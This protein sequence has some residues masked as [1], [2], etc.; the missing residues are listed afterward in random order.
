MLIAMVGLAV[1]L[2]AGRPA[3][4][5]V[6]QVWDEAHFLK[7][8]TIDPVDQVLNDIQSRFG[9]DLMIE[10]FASIPDDLKPNLQKD[11]KDKFYEGWSVSEGQEL[12]INGLLIL[13]TGDP[14]HIQV[15]VG[16]DT[17]KKAFTLADRDELL[18]VLANA[19]RQKDFDGGILRAAQFVR[20]RMTRNM[21]AG[22]GAATQPATAPATQPASN[23][24]KATSLP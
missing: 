11:G 24:E 20:D 10:T 21:A 8:Q 13:I 16:L 5:G 9:K 1:M 15:T 17:R 14:P 4:A 3:G 18:E 12:G 19:F 2:I 7:L 23:N 22:A 6:H